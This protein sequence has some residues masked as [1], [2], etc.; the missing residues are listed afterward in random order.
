MIVQSIPLVVVLQV[1]WISLSGGVCESLLKT[2]LL[3]SCDLVECP[4]VMIMR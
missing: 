1:R 4:K 2:M 3:W